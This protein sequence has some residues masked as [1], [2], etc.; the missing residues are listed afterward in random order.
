MPILPPL[1]VLTIALDRLMA[2]AIRADFPHA[3]IRAI[4]PLETGTASAG[5]TRPHLVILNASVTD[6]VTQHR[7]IR[8]EWG[9]GVI[10]V[11]LSESEPQA[12]VWR[13]AAEVDLVELRPGFLAPF[14]S[15]LALIAG[16]VV[17]QN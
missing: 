6:S 9:P 13:S 1:H 14:L 17:P 8:Q 4:P 15:G 12:L 3:D 11:E 5:V 7:L 2:D 10:V 16:T